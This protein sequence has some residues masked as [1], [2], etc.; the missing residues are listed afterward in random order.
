[1]VGAG[2]GNFLTVYRFLDMRRDIGL[3]IFEEG[4]LEEFRGVDFHV[5][6][7]V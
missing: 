5:G 7:Y 3:L 1:M 6:S 4:G 2:M